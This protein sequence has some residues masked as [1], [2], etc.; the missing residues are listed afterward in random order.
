MELPDLPS[1]SMLLARIVEGLDGLARIAS[2]VRAAG[3]GVQGGVAILGILALTVVG[4][5]ER[6]LAGLGGAAA[7]ALFAL[8]FHSR[9]DLMVGLGPAKAVPLFALIGGAVSAIIPRLFPFLAIALPAGLVGV[10]FPIAGRPWLGGLVVAVV[11]GLIAAVFARGAGI[12]LVSFVGGL[13]LT[14]AGVG[15]IGEH[16]LAASIDSRPLVLCGF[17]IVLGIAGSAYQL[18]LNRR[19]QG[20]RSSQPIEQPK[21]L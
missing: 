6:A 17:A 7:G 5:A 3:V 20:E 18:P 13:A 16:H 15:L 12:I 21:R 8:A 1:F 10:E 14:V 11:A 9:L 19:G 2:W 4:R